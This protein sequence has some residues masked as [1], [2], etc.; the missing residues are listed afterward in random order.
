MKKTIALLLAFAMCLSVVACSG[1]KSADTA[2]AP[3]A[4]ADGS[5]AEN[6]AAPGGDTGEVE[7]EVTLAVAVDPTTMAPW[8]SRNL[9]RINVLLN[10]YQCMVDEDPVTHDI[11]PTMLES[12]EQ[13]DEVTWNAKLYDYIC[14]SAGN[15]FTA[16]DIVYSFETAKA[17]GN[18]SKLN[19]I[20]S[21]T[22]LDDYTVQFVFTREL[23][24][25]EL[26]GIW[27]EIYV[28]TQAAYEASSNE[29]ATEPIGTGPYVVTE[30]V[31]GSHITFEKNE[32]YWQKE[33]LRTIFDMQN[34]DKITYEIITDA[35]QIAI[36]MQTGKV[37]TSVDV[38][39][40]DAVLFEDN[41][42]F[43]VSPV[44]NTAVYS[45]GY[46]CD[47]S[48][49]L[50]DLN[51]RLALSYAFD[52]Q[53]IV[54]LAY[55]GNAEVI[56]GMLSQSCIDYQA[57]WD[58]AGYDYFNY[59]LDKAK[60]YLQAYLDE[61]GK[62]AGDVTIRLLSGT[63]DGNDDVAE[64]MTSYWTALGINVDLQILD[65]ETVKPMLADPTAWDATTTLQFA[66]KNFASEGWNNFDAASYSWGGTKN[67]YYD[68]EFQAL[69]DKVGEV[70]YTAE[71][72]VAVQNY[73]DEKC[74][75]VG[76]CHN[77]FNIVHAN[78]ITEISLE[79]RT[80][81]LPGSCTYDW[82]LK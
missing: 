8:A 16:S 11:V 46:N 68:D 79:A 64:A 6:E 77:Y 72:V 5:N 24:V 15:P 78:F 70:E 61:S 28:C 71:D 59:D 63:A 21:V 80:C 44:P 81:M 56:H 43:I 58:E 49:V 51:L 82:S 12:Y 41:A 13:T 48:S 30:Y 2:A 76:I 35:S 26:L 9:G 14:D 1:S 55:S 45:I 40:T 75:A 52:S 27:N 67:F 47:E 10:V 62:Q 69:L 32:N 22:A 38:T 60:E 50:S 73:I 39:A 19:L 18:H 31:S 42:D 3:A 54:D 20:D 7:K 25:G 74:L 23:G 36:A 4:E 37:D 33:E 53:G 17:T 34:V 57:S 66:S 29:M 65:T